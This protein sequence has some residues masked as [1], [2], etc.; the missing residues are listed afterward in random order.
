MSSDRAYHT[1]KLH[2]Q[3][4]D[5]VCIMCGP[6]LQRPTRRCPTRARMPPVPGRLETSA[7]WSAPALSGPLRSST[8]FQ[9]WRQSGE[10]KTRPTNAGELENVCKNRQRTVATTDWLCQFQNKIAIACQ[11]L[12]PI[13][14]QRSGPFISQRQ[15]KFKLSIILYLRAIIPDFLY[16]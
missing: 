14:M 7:L 16:C 15:L 6:V 8:S 11:N 4:I 13:A 3:N 2:K 1:W 12:I 5:I 10:S 9:A